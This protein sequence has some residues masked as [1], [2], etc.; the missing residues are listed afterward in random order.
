[1]WENIK[2]FFSNLPGEHTDFYIL[3]G[4][5]LLA[6]ILL[7]IILF[8]YKHYR[9]KKAINDAKESE[10]KIEVLD[11]PS[12]DLDERV[13][14]LS[15]NLDS[16]NTVEETVVTNV[17]AS[18]LETPN[19]EEK[20]TEDVQVETVVNEVESIKETN[21]IL[22]DK[23][24]SD[25]ILENE[26]VKK[27]ISLVRYRK[28]FVA[29]LVL[30]P[31]L[32]DLYKAIRDKFLSYRKVHARLSFKNE[33]FS[34]GRTTLAKLQV[35]GKRL[36]LYLNL[37][38]KKLD[39]KYHVVDVSEKKIGEQT[40]SLL[41]ILSQRSLNYALQLIELLMSYN[42]VL[43]LPEDKIEEFDYESL[44]YPRTL[45]ELI[46]QKLVVEYTVN[47][48]VDSDFDESTLVLDEED[49]EDEGISE[50]EAE[51]IINDEVLDQN[52]T[53]VVKNRTG[54]TDIVNIDSLNTNFKSGDVVDL[55]ALK[56]VGLISKK[57]KRVKVLAR[58][59]INKVLH[60]EADSFSKG[61]MKMIVAK[62][63]TVIVIK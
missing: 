23:P 33:R 50:E 38:P 46:E 34:L 28:S 14:V 17:E 41:R 56:K 27:T 36:Y 3:L 57:A 24:S 25:V 5:A 44:L 52:I 4:V 63:G 18:S 8:S 40:P 22:E 16:D 53:V 59:K 32:Q 62:G 19:V 51:N 13:D 7:L 61:A 39:E 6:I 55:A 11:I 42:S 49:D 58:G 35:R 60:V 15:G 47:K 20:V 30:R 21:E 29:Q 9:K 12:V 43:P 1:M 54:K 31:E 2:K 26:N 10:T 37:D 48:V 45:A